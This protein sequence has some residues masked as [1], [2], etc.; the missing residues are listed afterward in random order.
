MIR[1]IDAAF[2][3]ISAETA[4]LDVAANNIANINTD[5]YKAKQVNQS[6][7]G[8]GQITTQVIQSDQEVNL[9]QESL[10]MHS[11]KFGFQADIAVIRAED[12]TMRSLLDIK[13]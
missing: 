4:R 9:V 5:G 8:N 1:G 2:S 10:N 7:D 6:V 3:G 11:A 13:V 12:E